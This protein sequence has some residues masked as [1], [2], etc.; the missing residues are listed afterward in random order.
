MWQGFYVYLVSI[1]TQLRTGK[2]GLAKFLH[3][4][5]VPGYESALLC[6]PYDIR[7]IGV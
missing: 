2:I 6:M 7:R 4:M 5:R 1:A 3:N